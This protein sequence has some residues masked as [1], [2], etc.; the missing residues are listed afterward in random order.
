MKKKKDAVSEVALAI[1]LVSAQSRRIIN[2][3][4]LSAVVKSADPGGV[5]PFFRSLEVLR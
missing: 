1:L 3:Q 4:R 2:I 5:V